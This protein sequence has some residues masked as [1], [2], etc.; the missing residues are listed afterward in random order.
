[1]GYQTV[2]PDAGPVYRA[3]YL[4]TAGAR[5][6]EN[7][8]AIFADR[9]RMKVQKTGQIHRKEESVLAAADDAAGVL[10]YKP[11]CNG[12]TVLFQVPRFERFCT[13]ADAA[14]GSCTG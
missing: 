12:Y 13:R 14:R 8:I 11:F 5:R 10:G 3:S 4:R 6:R 7:G 2:G 9:I 1:M